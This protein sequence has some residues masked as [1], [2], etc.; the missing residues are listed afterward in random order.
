MEAEPERLRDAERL[1]ADFEAAMQRARELAEITR[2]LLVVTVELV[3]ERRGQIRVRRVASA[4]QR[5]RV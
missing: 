2:E 1:Q 3:E 4:R 5:V